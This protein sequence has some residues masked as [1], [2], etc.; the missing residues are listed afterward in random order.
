MPQENSLESSGFP[1]KFYVFL[2]LGHDKCLHDKCRYSFDGCYMHSFKRNRIH[3]FQEEKETKHI[4]FGNLNASFKL[5]NIKKK[6]KVI[7]KI[8]PSCYKYY[9][10]FLTGNKMRERSLFFF[11][12]HLHH[13]VD[14]I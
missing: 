13:A 9:A 5:I 4:I 2:P 11:F 12:L 1:Q 3:D 14:S 10:I 6:A 7:L 8:S